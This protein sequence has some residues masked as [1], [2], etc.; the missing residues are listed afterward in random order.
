[1]KR[2]QF[3]QLSA[4]ATTSL[5]FGQTT[6][7]AASVKCPILMYHYVS[8]IPDDANEYLKDLAVHPDHFTEHCRWLVENG[9]VSVTMAQ[10]YD[11]LVNGTPLPEN[12]VVLTFDDGYW[13]AFAYATPILQQFGMVGTFFIVPGYMEAP[14]HLTWDQAA[15]MLGAGME[16]ENHSMNHQRLSGRTMEFLLEEVGVAADTIEAVLGKRPRFFCYPFGRYDDFAVNAV[17]DT[18]HLMAVTTQDGTLM[19]S[20]N[21]YRLRRVRI[22]GWTNTGTLRWLVNRKI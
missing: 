14:G 13:D 18:G 4:L 2:R 10:L 5:L 15:A 11:N 19:Y 17:R 16:I 20:T 1:M 8:P 7:E 12:P 3:L 22:R 9:F 21:M 6:A